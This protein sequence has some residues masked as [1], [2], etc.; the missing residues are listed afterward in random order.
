MIAARGGRPTWNPPSPYGYPESVQAAGM[1]VAPLL[2]GF[3]IAL[4]GLTVDTSNLGVRYRD[5]AL[6]VLTGAVAALLAAIQCAYSARRYLALPDE[7]AAWWPGVE[8]D[9]DAGEIEQARE[10]QADQLAHRLLHE[11]WATRFRVVYHAGILLVLAGLAIVLIPPDPKDAHITTVRWAAVVLAASAAAAE[12][13]WIAATALT[14]RRGRG[15]ASRVVVA[16][17]RRLVPSYEVRLRD[18]RAALA[19]RRLADTVAAANVKSKLAELLDEAA[20]GFEDGKVDTA[21]AK[22]ACFK[23]L[24]AFELK[25]GDVGAFQVNAWTTAVDQIAHDRGLGP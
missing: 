6:L 25:G 15:R 20:N 19:L 9:Q 13:L 7:I 12:L 22:L 2:A 5:T 23:R 1:I 21:R 8:S 17:A 24:L 16:T 14:S 10:L 11:R 18:A 4:I 3:T